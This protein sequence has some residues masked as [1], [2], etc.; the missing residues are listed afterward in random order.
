MVGF[1]AAKVC[2]NAHSFF[3]GVKGDHAFP[4]TALVVSQH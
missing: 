1:R 4:E 3:R 2:G